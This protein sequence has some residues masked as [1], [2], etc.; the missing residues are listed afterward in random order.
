LTRPVL[1][2]TRGDARIGIGHVL[3]SLEL[4]QTFI[5]PWR[6]SIHVDEEGEASRVIQQRGG[7]LVMGPLLQTVQAL[8][9][10]I[11]IVDRPDPDAGVLHALRRVVPRLR[12]VGLDYFERDRSALDLVINLWNRGKTSTAET[13]HGYYE[14]L[15][16][17]IIRRRF[18][19]FR[20][21]KVQFASDI[22][23]VLV[24]FGG[25]DLRHATIETIQALDKRVPAGFDVD[26][27][28]GP[29]CAETNRIARA[30][31]S[32]RQRFTVHVDP[33][34]VEAIM[35]A[36][37]LAITGGG[38]T[39]VELCYLGIPSVVYPATPEEQG[40]AALFERVGAVCLGDSTTELLAHV[41]RLCSDPEQRLDMQVHAQALID[42]EGPQRIL[43]LVLQ[44]KTR[45]AYA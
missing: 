39:L 1:I 19:P 16:Y 30:I 22:R 24:T 41:T 26:V 15:E 18:V 36:A 37:D 9:P 27:L 17:A 3:R 6:A 33:P 7:P 44:E 21:A 34:D 38:T 2:T 10:E 28:A 11:L 45:A 5:G 32:V 12:I 42:G 20:R 40:F 31:R 14:G 13:G 35:G 4:V 25:A 29:L 8:L 23:R 43:D